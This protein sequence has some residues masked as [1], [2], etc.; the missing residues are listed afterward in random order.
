MTIQSEILEQPERLEQL[1]RLQKKTAQDIARAVRMRDIH[2]VF[3]AARGT[4]DNAGRY[5]NY[6]WGAINHLPVALATPS[7]FTYYQQPPNLK[8]AL[9]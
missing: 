7:L 5:A 3:L 4:S 1:L 6:I 8:N 9:V 2:Y